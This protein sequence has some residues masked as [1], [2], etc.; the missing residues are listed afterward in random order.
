MPSIFPMQRTDPRFFLT[1]PNAPS[2][3]FIVALGAALLVA[4]GAALLQGC[5]TTAPRNNAAQLWTMETS[6]AL[7][8]AC[9]NNTYGAS[10][11]EVTDAN[12]ILSK[13]IADPVTSTRWHQLVEN[14]IVQNWP[15]D[16]AAG[17]AKNVLC[18]ESLTNALVVHYSER[19]THWCS[20]SDDASGVRKKIAD[21]V[22]E[23]MAPDCTDLVRM[24]ETGCFIRETCPPGGSGYQAKKR[25]ATPVCHEG[26]QRIH[27]VKDPKNINLAWN[28]PFVI[29]LTR[30]QSA[31]RTTFGM[32]NCHGTAQ[33]AAG[34]LLSDLKLE[35]VTFA[36]LADE[37][38]CGKEAAEFLAANREKPLA[39]VDLQPGGIIIN[40]KHDD[41]TA[42]DCG[43]VKL[44]IDTCT[45]EDPRANR[46]FD[47]GVFIDGMCVACWGKM[48]EAHGLKSEPNGAVRSGCILTAADHSVF[49]VQRSAGWCFTYEATSPFGPPQLRASPCL[50][51]E[52]RFENRYCPLL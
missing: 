12:G 39:K 47:S 44:W 21:A 51:L 43:T 34:E 45:P 1:G 9:N 16:F 4:L 7:Q 27:K 10:R 42:T 36:R 18:L 22:S 25:V 19:M 29:D 52:L 49:M 14:R 37:P 17:G 13:C 33:A 28:D 26:V 5:Q 2:A 20:S 3:N 41:C 48:L 46:A 24:T 32:P 31:A 8:R 50:D 11:E 6:E 15:D 30:S 23:M 35:S 38:R 40:M